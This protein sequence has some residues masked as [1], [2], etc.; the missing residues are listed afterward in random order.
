M[1]AGASVPGFTLS[2]DNVEDL[3]QFSDPEQCLG[4]FEILEK[5]TPLK[6]KLHD[7]IRNREVLEAVKKCLVKGESNEPVNCVRS[8]EQ[9]TLEFRTNFGL[10]F[11]AIPVR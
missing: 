9:I 7:E 2:P 3:R 11:V 10:H 5:H 4:I 1:L 6:S 8:V